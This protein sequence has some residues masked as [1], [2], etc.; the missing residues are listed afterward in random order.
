MI[1]TTF[2][3]QTGLFISSLPIVFSVKSDQEYS[4]I[5]VGDNET[6]E[7]D[8]TTDELINQL[9]RCKNKSAPGADGINYLI[10]KK[11][12]MNALEHLTGIFQA[13]YTVGYFPDQWKKMRLSK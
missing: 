7:V 3:F 9:R 11:L 10:L 8:I 5:E 4:E 1:W 6:T 2:S 12:P 13:A